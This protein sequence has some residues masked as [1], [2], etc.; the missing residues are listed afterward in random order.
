MVARHN[1]VE[2]ISRDIISHEIFSLEFLSL[3]IF[4]EGHFFGDII[5]RD[6][7]SAILCRGIGLYNDLSQY[8]K[9]LI[10]I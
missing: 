10:Y 1:I 8:C 6:I 2:K 4:E 9:K 5:S 3:I 7:F